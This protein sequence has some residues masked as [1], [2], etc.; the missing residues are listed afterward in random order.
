MP[1]VVAVE[2]ALLTGR[3]DL[4]VAGAVA[5][6]APLALGFYL[7][8]R[9]APRGYLLGV[10]GLHVERR[11][12]DLVVPY[13][14]IRGV[15]RTKRAFV[16]LGAGSK[17]FLGDFTFGRAWRPGLGRYRLCLTNRQN[18]VWLQTSGGWIAVSPDRADEFVA[19][20]SARLSMRSRLS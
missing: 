1:V 10:D 17:G 19:R 16:G 3:L 13:H 7:T 20:L 4:A 12:S 8:A 6:G 14:T 11:A 9:Y 15:D 18:A 2:V 5:I